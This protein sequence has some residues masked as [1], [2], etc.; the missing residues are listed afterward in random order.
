MLTAAD[1]AGGPLT[2]SSAARLT[3]LRHRIDGAGPE[4]GDPGAAIVWVRSHL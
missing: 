1:P 3:A 2:A 4:R